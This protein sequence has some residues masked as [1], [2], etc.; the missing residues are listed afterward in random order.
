MVGVQQ[1]NRV[2]RMR[3]RSIRGLGA[4]VLAM[5]LLVA[6]GPV[7][8]HDR[9][10]DHEGQSCSV[11]LAGRSVGTLASPTSIDASLGLVCPAEILPTSNAPRSERRSVIFVRGPPPAEGFA[12]PFA[13]WLS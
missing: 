12:T 2:H 6:M 7:A 13:S 1:Q 3:H 5:L 8:A 10:G 11:C 9:A 4:T